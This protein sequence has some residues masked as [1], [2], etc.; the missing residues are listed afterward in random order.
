MSPECPLCGIP[1]GTWLHG[2]AH[3][4][5]N[6]VCQVFTFVRAERAER[7]KALMQKVIGIQQERTEH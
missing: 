4:C 6:P 1:G 7:A 3:I 5:L 2:E